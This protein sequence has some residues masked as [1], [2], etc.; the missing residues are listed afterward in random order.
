MID[1]LATRQVPGPKSAELLDISSQTEP[2]CIADQ[3]PVVWDHGERV[4]VT[5]VDGNRY[6]DFTSGVLVTNVGHS[7]PAHVEA[8]QKQAGRTRARR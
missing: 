1:K 7:H 5:D 6:I 8:I 4:W 3:V 2:P